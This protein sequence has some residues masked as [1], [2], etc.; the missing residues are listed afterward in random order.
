MTEAHSC[1]IASDGQ[2]PEAGPGRR[3]AGCCKAGVAV[4]CLIEQ[5]AKRALPAF[6]ES[7]NSERPQELLPRMPREVEERVD[8]HDRHLFRPGG[9]LDDLVARL[10]LALFDHPEVE[11]GPVVGDEQ[12]GNPRV[13]HPNPDPEARHSRLGD[14]EDCGADSVAIA[15]ADLLVAQA[16]DREVLA[17]LSVDEV[18]SAEL[19][20]PVAIRLDLVDEDCPVLAAVG[21][22]IRLLVSVDV[23]LAHHPRAFDRVLPDGSTH[24]LSLPLDVTRLAD[25]ER[26]KP[27]GDL[28]A[29]CPFGRLHRHTELARQHPCWAHH[30]VPRRRGQAAGVGHPSPQPLVG[31]GSSARRPQLDWRGAQRRGT[32][33]F[34]AGQPRRTD[35]LERLVR[36]GLAAGTAELLN[37]AEFA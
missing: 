4:A 3:R 21:F 9:E 5:G 19:A 23:D 13:V 7:G 15:D 10:H 18:V 34:D 28:S 27:T 17:E 31:N 25:V 24:R 8:F 16:L 6:A 2:M 11:A 1:S 37:R 30:A 22:P 29:T 35:H 36:A 26:Q 20:F 14:F 33:A 12:G 32:A